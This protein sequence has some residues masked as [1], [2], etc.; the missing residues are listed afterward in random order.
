M[1]PQEIFWLRLHLTAGLGRQRLIQLIHHYGS[2]EA[3][4]AV[5]PQHWAEHAQVKS[6]S[7]GTPPEAQ[8]PTFQKAVTRLDQLNVRL[9]SLWDDDYPQALRHISDPPALLYL[10]GQ[11]PE[12][13]TL[14]LVGSRRCSPAGQRWTEK[15]AH[16]LS[17]HNLTIVSGLARG[18]D[19]AAHRGALKGPGSTIAV[20]G[21]GIDLIYPKENRH[22]FEQIGEKGI[23]VSEYP[24]GTAPK[25]GNFPGRNR[26]ISGLSEGVVIIEAALQS[27]SL[28]TAD[29]ALEQGRDVF[30]VPGPPYDSQVAGC[31]KLI[32]DGATLVCQPQ[33]ILDHFGLTEHNIAVEENEPT[34]PPL[35]NSQ[36]MVLRKLGKTPRHLDKLATESGLTPMEV[37]AIVLHLELLGLAQSLPGGHYI[38]AFPS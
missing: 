37:S 18:I 35:S 33:D 12:K 20:L 36:D 11:W 31:L 24:P 5:S 34:V 25:P 23:I 8:D 32:H 13:R 17:Q 7:L 4:L 30:A 19:S 10:R 2:A 14:A 1:T 29:F 26:I 6:K 15:L 9:T 3:A 28:I 22:L 27:G 16:T 21:C 38:R